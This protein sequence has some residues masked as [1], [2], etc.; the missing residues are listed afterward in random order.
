MPDDTRIFDESGWSHGQ[1]LIAYCGN[2][3]RETTHVFHEMPEEGDLY[4][5][6]DARLELFWLCLGCGEKKHVGYVRRL[7]R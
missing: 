7:G 1:S 4:R 6:P 3:E 2:C 5:E